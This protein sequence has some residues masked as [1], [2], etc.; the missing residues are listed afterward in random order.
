MFRNETI[1]QKIVEWEH[2]N[3]ILNMTIKSISFNKKQIKETE[4][5]LEMCSKIIDH[6]NT[7]MVKI[8]KNSGTFESRKASEADMDI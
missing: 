7:E 4:M 5:L 6:A 8:R 3:S 1:I 2:A